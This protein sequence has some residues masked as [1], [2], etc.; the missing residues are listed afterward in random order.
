MV[1]NF[2]SYDEKH[3]LGDKFQSAYT[4]N[5]STETAL[6]RVTNDLLTSLDGKKAMVLTLLDLSAAFDTI[7]HNTLLKRRK[8][9]YGVCDTALDWMQSYLSE[10]MQYTSIGSS[11]S[12][13]IPLLYGVPQGSILGSI[14]V[15]LVQNMTSA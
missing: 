9:N 1:N 5:C 4:K 6:L 12:S 10:R 15:Y 8:D 13:E 14:I 7:D 11:S 3:G 2:T